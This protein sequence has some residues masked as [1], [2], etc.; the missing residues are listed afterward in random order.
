MYKYLILHLFLLVIS[1]S[2]CSNKPSPLYVP[3]LYSRCPP[4]FGRNLRAP[5]PANLATRLVNKRSDLLPGYTLNAVWRP[6]NCFPY[7]VMTNFASALTNVSGSPV[8]GVIGP[9]Q[10]PAARY[11]STLVGKERIASLHLHLDGAFVSSDPNSTLSFSMLDSPSVLQQATLA[12][13]ERRSWQH[14]SVLYQ[15]GYMPYD[16]MKLMRE[17]DNMGV[18]YNLSQLNLV[19]SP[20]P[21]REQFQL[22][23][24]FVNQFLIPIILCEAYHSNI[25]FPKYQILIVLPA[26]TIRPVLPFHSFTGRRVCTAEQLLAAAEGVL[27][28]QHQIRPI[29]PQPT[30]SG[31][32]YA[33]LEGIYGPGSAPQNALIIDAVWSLA[34]ALNN[35][36]QTLND[37]HMS[38]S[39]FSVNGNYDATV[40]IREELAR[41]DFQ[42]VT[43]QVDFS[44]TRGY[45]RRDTA[46]VQFLREG[47]E[48]L[49][50]E[51]VGVFFTANTSLVLY[52][53]LQS[54]NRNFP[55]PCPFYIVTPPKI[56]GIITFIITTALTLYIIV[57]HV[58]TLSLCKRKSIKASSYKLSQLTYFGCYI[59]MISI[60]ANTALEVYPDV[61]SP[62]TVC[63]LLHAALITCFLSLTLIYGSLCVRTWRLYRIF[64]HFRKPGRFLSDNIL[65]AGVFIWLCFDVVLSIAWITTDPL[66]PTCIHLEGSTEQGR[67]DCTQKYYFFWVY[68]LFVF[69]LILMIL[70]VVFGLLTRSKAKLDYYLNSTL[71]GVFVSIGNLV[72]DMPFYFV[73]TLAFRLSKVAITYRY[74]FLNAMFLLV[75]IMVSVFILTPPLTPIF[76]E[77]K[78]SFIAYKDSDRRSSS[79]STRVLMVSPTPPGRSPIHR[80]TQSSTRVLMVSPSPPGRSPIHQ[81][82][83]TLL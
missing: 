38:L 39:D 67:V 61:L 52:S 5:N 58:L 59:C 2:V 74:S 1:H 63:N 25:T 80:L 82:T 40:L 19:R 56:T 15:P 22:Q 28:V 8:V 12:L 64:V 33:Q 71:W 50:T 69:N 55:F 65:L 21:L 29:L 68:L 79:S 6:Y 24:F 44:T 3:V 10:T 4:N 54:T 27:M 42:G 57:I 77:W 30:L 83:Q 35:S 47:N 60:L 20:I 45:I 11:V 49:T 31:L 73:F 43:G 70:C 51:Q 62:Q 14:V 18:S 26:L 75:A 13:I 78:E 7:S 53:S 37:Q 17:L 16:G 72:I 81:L 76:K 34:L 9:A 66:A 23:L 48:S 41:L 32:T 36:I 46:I